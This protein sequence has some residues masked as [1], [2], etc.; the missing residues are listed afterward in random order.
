MN[1]RVATAEFPIMGQV[2]DKRFDDA[3]DGLRKLIYEQAGFLAKK[4]DD[5]AKDDVLVANRVLVIETERGGEKGQTIK[6]ASTTALLIS[7][8]GALVSLYTLWKM[9]HP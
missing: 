8:P 4:I 1:A 3:I 6:R 7:A 2:T 9:W 5:H